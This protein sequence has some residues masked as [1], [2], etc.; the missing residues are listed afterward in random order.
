MLVH[1][2]D[3]NRKL[4]SPMRFNPQSVTSAIWYFSSS[5][6]RTYILSWKTRL[7]DWSTLVLGPISKLNIG[8]TTASK[9]IK[10]DFKCGF[11]ELAYNTIADPVGMSIVSTVLVALRSGS[12]IS[13]GAELARAA[14][15]PHTFIVK[16]YLVVN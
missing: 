4:K 11:F 6:P 13:V 1:E 9:S 8:L 7:H 2:P 12:I 14:R 3:T 15:R 5:L 10:N 16:I